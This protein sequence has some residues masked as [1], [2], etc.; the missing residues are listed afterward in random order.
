MPRVYAT[1][2]DDA[3][4]DRITVPVSPLLHERVRAFAANLSIDKTSLARIL[5]E[6]GLRKLDGRALTAEVL[7][8]LRGEM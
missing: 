3:K 8:E 4:R 6:H 2:G 5:I 7:G 1:K